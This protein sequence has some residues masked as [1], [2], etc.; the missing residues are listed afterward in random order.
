[1]SASNSRETSM[2]PDPPVITQ[3]LYLRDEEVS[4]ELGSAL[5][6]ALIEVERFYTSHTQRASFKRYF[7]SGHVPDTGF[8]T[9]ALHSIT[10]ALR[11]RPSRENELVLPQGPERIEREVPVTQARSRLSRT[12]YNQQ[13]LADAMR[14]EVKVPA[15]DHRVLI[16]TDCEITAP[17]EWRYIISD[18]VEGGTVLSI[19][20]L[21]PRYWHDPEPNRVAVVKKRMRASALG[22]TGEML[23]LR[24]CSNP[25][26]YLFENVDSVVRLD[27]MTMIGEEHKGEE[28]NVD[29]LTSRG[30]GAETEPEPM[31]SLQS[32]RVS[33]SE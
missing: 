29:M 13:N 26:C 8:A 1:M 28:G 21:D 27:F 14:Q 24:N 25:R 4:K 17:P 33:E 32:I 31:Q 10:R 20:P 19:A 6:A 30:F 16:V 23:G 18:D 15:E 11:N 5:W 3:V 7:V 2:T 9:S 12:T 22:T